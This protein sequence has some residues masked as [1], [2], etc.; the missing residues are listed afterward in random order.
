MAH[1]T[2]AEHGRGGLLHAVLQLADQ[3]LDLA[4]GTL[5][6]LGQ[7]AHLVGHHRETTAGLAGAGGLDGGVERQQVG[8][9][10]HRADH[11]QHIADLRAVLMQAGH[12]LG[13]SL[14]PGGQPLDLGDGVLHHLVAPAG[15]LAGELR[16]ASGLPGV[17]GHLLHRVGHLLHGG[18]DLDG[19]G[20][21]LLDPGA[22]LFGDG[23]QRLGRAADLAHPAADTADQLAQAVLHGL[24]G[25]L[26]LPQ[27]VAAC[28]RRGAA[29]IA[30]GDAP[31]LGQGLSQ[32]ADDL[33]GDA[34]GRQQGH[35]QGHPGNRQ[36]LQAHIRGF[37]VAPLQQGR[38]QLAAQALHRL[39]P[40]G[41]AGG[42]R[43][44]AGDALAK[45]LQGLLEALQRLKGFAED[46]AA[47]F[48]QLPL[49][50]AGGL[51]QGRAG[52]EGGPLPLGRWRAHIDQGEQAQLEE[53]LVEPAYRAD[54]VE[55]G[56]GVE[57]L[58]QVLEELRF[59]TSES[60]HALLRR[61]D[62]EAA[63]FLL[64][65]AGLRQR[66]KGFA[67]G[68]GGL[69]HPGHALAVAGVVEQAAEA[70]GIR[71]HAGGELLD[72]RTLRLLALGGEVPPRPVGLEEAQVEI[73]AAD[74]LVPALAE[75]VQ[76]EYGGQGDQQRQQQ[77][78]GEAQGQLVADA[79]VGQPGKVKWRHGRARQGGGG[80]RRRRG[81][82]SSN[83]C[84]GWCGKSTR[85]CA[86]RWCW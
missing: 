55:H 26:Q 70:L 81:V 73:T 53:L 71:Q 74:Q 84:S 62:A 27:L 39:R 21:L 52:V 16:G 1:V 58:L 23:G 40:L 33:P 49:Q 25:L 65:G 63:G 19:F 80:P 48:R 56:M 61:R 31:G 41:H 17:A 18:G 37:P 7:A 9:L 76:A 86:R 69:A 59:E 66:G 24:H 5:H 4:G 43:R 54:L 79:Q 42:G 30:F 36:Q 38:L 6:P 28:G 75:A 57:Q 35:Q 64:L 20:L 12:H 8:L 44:H 83:R 29:E 10:G 46:G 72:P 34:P 22:G 68:A 32:G 3:F 50:G 13:R 60:L 82:R 67:I 2:A 14:H 15:L 85:R 77:Y 51:G 45:T 47:A 78:Q 11:I